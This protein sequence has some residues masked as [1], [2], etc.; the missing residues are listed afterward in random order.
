MLLLYHF[1]IVIFLVPSSPVDLGILLNYV[2]LC[3]LIYFLY[4]KFLNKLESELGLSWKISKCPPNMR[5][6]SLMVKLVSAYGMSKCM[7]FWY[8]KDYKRHFD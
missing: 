5:L 2:N 1:S 8:S 4:H 6:R 7:P 3:V